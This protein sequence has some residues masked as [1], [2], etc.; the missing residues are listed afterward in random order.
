MLR[1]VSFKSHCS[2]GYLTVLVVQIWSSN[3]PTVNEI[4]DLHQNSETVLSKT[5]LENQGDRYLDRTTISLF[6]LIF[7]TNLS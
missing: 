2:V 6:Y 5:F 3:A 1:F 7:F 4:C